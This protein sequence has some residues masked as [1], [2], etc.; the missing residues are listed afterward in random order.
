MPFGGNGPPRGKLSAVARTDYYDDPNAPEPNSLVVAA[1]AVVTDEHGR[2]LLQRRRD[3]DLWR[4]ERLDD[5]R[6]A[7]LRGVA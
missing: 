6:D 4:L 2:L 5:G 1:S 3:S 7:L